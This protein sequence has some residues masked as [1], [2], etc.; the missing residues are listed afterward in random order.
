[1]ESRI[2]GCLAWIN[3]VEIIYWI[4]LI[5]FECYSVCT[6]YFTTSFLNTNVCIKTFH[7]NITLC[8]KVY[9]CISITHFHCKALFTFKTSLSINYN[10]ENE[11]H[12]VS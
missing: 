8:V 5:L 11:K 4:P 3:R 7:M 6:V 12:C 2:Q 10:Y 1:M 9:T